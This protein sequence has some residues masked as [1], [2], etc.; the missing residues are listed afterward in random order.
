[1]DEEIGGDEARDKDAGN[2][3]E[4]ARPRDKATTLAEEAREAGNEKKGYTHLHLT[5]LGGA[6]PPRLDWL[7]PVREGG[8][9]GP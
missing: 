8:G 9:G 5:P 4:D 6:A 1:M 2:T 3:S 7:R